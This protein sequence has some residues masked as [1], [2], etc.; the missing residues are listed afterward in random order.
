MYNSTQIKVIGK[1][2]SIRSSSETETEIE[3]EQNTR[4]TNEQW[5][6]CLEYGTVPS[7][8]CHYNSCLHC[9][10][11]TCILCLSLSVCGCVA[12]V[13]KIKSNRTMRYHGL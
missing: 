10:Y 12:C 8:I 1:A 13:C 3:I 4:A 9:L 11:A 5:T 6:V 2:S 7:V